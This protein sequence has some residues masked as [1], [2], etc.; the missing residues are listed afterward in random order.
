[1]DLREQRTLAALMFESFQRHGNSIDQA[2]EQSLEAAEK[3]ILRSIVREKARS[4]AAAAQRE[5]ERLA[6]EERERAMAQLEA[7]RSNGSERG[8]YPVFPASS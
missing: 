7:E 3:L 1:M 5:R 2:V 4:E 6:A 8:T